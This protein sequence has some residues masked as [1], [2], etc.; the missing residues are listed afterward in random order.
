MNSNSS[1]VNLPGLGTVSF[2]NP[3]SGVPCTS[4]AAGCVSIAT[5][6][7]ESI[8]QAAPQI[9]A[10]K[11]YYQSQ[12]Q[13]S[14]TANPS[15]I[16]TGDNLYADNIYAA[17]FVVPY[18]IQFNGG[19]Q[20]QI[21]HGLI[22]S[23]D[24]VH[25]ATLKLPTSIDVN[26]DGAARTLNVA[27]AKNAI[28]TTLANCS[29][30]GAPLT[31]D[32]AL[33]S[34]PGLHPASGN[35]PAG[36]ATI[37]DFASSGLDSGVSFL[38]GGSAGAAGLTPATGAAFPGNNPNVG[39]G[40]FI[41]PQGRSGYDAL[42]LVLQQQTNHP[43]P[44]IVSSNLQISYSLSRIVSTSNS[45]NS[46]DQSFEG[47]HAYDNDNPALY[48]GRNNLDHTHELNMGGSMNIK[49]GPQ[50]GFI[51]HFYSAPPSTLTLDNTGGTTGQIFQTDVFGD[52]EASNQGVP[53]TLGA[54]PES[55]QL[56]A[57]R[58]PGQSQPVHQLL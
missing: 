31:I 44:G 21:G 55:G 16:G 23:A 32:L 25:N 8:A 13:G 50:V 6:S 15:Y 47:S 20:Q 48:L 26:H 18:S 34:C 17:P 57:F 1:S 3:T 43:L 45:G 36:P 5:V 53:G 11:N 24:Y 37:Q 33:Q 27:A 42:Q 41:L 49:Y 56:H 4:L 19:I 7:N 58:P 40:L 29:A 12:V 51:A 35:S 38:S 30:G 46:A 52:G 2:F 9:N 54:R 39:E 22:F 10:L 28:A 14:A